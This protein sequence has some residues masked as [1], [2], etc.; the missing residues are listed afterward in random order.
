MYKQQM[1]HALVTRDGV[2][3]QVGQSVILQ[4]RPNFGG[5]QIKWFD[6]TKLLKKCSLKFE[7]RGFLR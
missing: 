6:D 7:K 2:V 4:P 1:Q 3:N 5:G